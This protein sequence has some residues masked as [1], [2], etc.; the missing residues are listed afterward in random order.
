MRTGARFLLSVVGLVL[1]LSAVALVLLLATVGLGCATP[2]PEEQPAGCTVRPGESQVEIE[3]APAPDAAWSEEALD[4]AEQG[5]E[6]RSP[7]GR[8]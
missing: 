8:P 4:E 3:C 2:A 6:Q 5:M 7:G 1:P